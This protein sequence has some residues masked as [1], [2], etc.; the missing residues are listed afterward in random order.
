MRLFLI[1][2]KYANVG[3]EDFILLVGYKIKND[4]HLMSYSAIFNLDQITPLFVNTIFL[5]QKVDWKIAL[6]IQKAN[7]SCFQ[8]KL[9][10][11]GLGTNNHKQQ[12]N[13]WAE[14]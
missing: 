3:T 10:K 9:T 14:W 7:V 4:F 12:E 6:Q 11:L 5:K 8:F 1:S 13:Y 2:I